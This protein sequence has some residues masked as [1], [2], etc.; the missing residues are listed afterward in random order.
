M[1]RDSGRPAA[2]TRHVQRTVALALIAFSLAGSIAAATV[3]EAGNLHPAY[4]VVSFLAW[5]SAAAAVVLWA[6][7]PRN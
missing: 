1:N 7:S 3:Y 6:R 4:A 2:A 5:G